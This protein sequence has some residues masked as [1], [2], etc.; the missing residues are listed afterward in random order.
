S[1]TRSHWAADGG[2]LAN[3]PIRPILDS[4]F[5]QPSHG[6]QVRRALLYIVPDPG[7]TPRP[8]DDPEPARIEQ[9]LALPRALVGDMTSA[10]NQSTAAG[11]PAIQQH[12]ERVDAMRDSRLRLAELGVA[13]T[14]AAPASDPFPTDGAWNDY[15]SRQGQWVVR[16]LVRAVMA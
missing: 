13:V 7:G 11:L 9:P 4:I 2:L 5:E 10:L 16:P 15:V 8:V 3:R 1:I 14:T 6:R 12:N